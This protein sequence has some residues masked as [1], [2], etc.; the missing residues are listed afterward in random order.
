MLFYVGKDLARWA[1]QCMELVENTEALR[2]SSIR[3]ESFLALLIENTPAAVDAKLRRWGVYEYR[4][5]FARAVG[6]HAIF[7]AL[8]DYESL[9]ADFVRYYHRF[10]D[11]LYSCRQQLFPFAP[12]LPSNFDF[13]LYS[14]A[15]YARLLESQWESS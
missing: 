4:T 8:P 6:M 9:S 1:S 10:A 3:A 7:Q 5:I 14:S 15:E 12:I 11:Q 2:H 13:E